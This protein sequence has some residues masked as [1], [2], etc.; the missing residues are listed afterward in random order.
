MAVSLAHAGA[1]T[2]AAPSTPA[3]VGQLA[4]FPL[5]GAGKGGLYVDGCA[6]VELEHQEG[7]RWVPEP[8]AACPSPT[9][10]MEVSGALAVSAVVPRAGTWRA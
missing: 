4:T 5:A 10:A 7:D 1:P 8:I 2:L 6:P 9:P 3:V